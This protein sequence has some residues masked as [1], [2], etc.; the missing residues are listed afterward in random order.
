MLRI[1]Y[2]FETEEY[3]PVQYM[4]NCNS[5]GTTQITYIQAYAGNPDILEVL[6]NG[7]TI[8]VMPNPCLAKGSYSTVIYIQDE[9]GNTLYELPVTIRV[10][11]EEVPSILVG[12]VN[13][14]GEVNVNDATYLQMYL[15][16][17]KNDDGSVMLDT[18]DENVFAVADVNDDGDIN[19]KDVTYIQMMIADLV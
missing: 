1:D 14:D 3:E 17:Y 12:D 7:M 18:T 10:A 19:I 8:Y 16:D 13:L 11:Q 9:N 5:V 4:I 2:D 15:V 6:S